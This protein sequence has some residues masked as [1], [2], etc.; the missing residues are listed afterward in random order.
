MGSQTCVLHRDASSIGP[1][2][3][4]ITPRSFRFH[5]HDEERHKLVINWE[6]VQMDAGTSFEIENGYQK[7]M[8]AYTSLY[9]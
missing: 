1:I 9:T 3:Q 2:D 6:W 4:W 8:I 5:Y 7:Y